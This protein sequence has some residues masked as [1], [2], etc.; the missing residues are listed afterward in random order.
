MNKLKTEQE[1]GNRIIDNFMF[2]KGRMIADDKLPPYHSS[3]DWLMPVVE[4]IESI[5]NDDYLTITIRDNKCTIENEQQ[6][7]NIKSSH[8]SANKFTAIYSACLKFIQWYN[9]QPSKS[10]SK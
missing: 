8:D 4:K 7:I 1:K 3:W 2:K 10:Q 9:K 5:F 6:T